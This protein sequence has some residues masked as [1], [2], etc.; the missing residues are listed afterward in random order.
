VLYLLG[1]IVF[2]LD[3]NIAWGCYGLHANITDLDGGICSVPSSLTDGDYTSLNHFP[4]HCSKAFDGSGASD[5]IL[6]DCLH[7]PPYN[8]SS[9]LHVIAH[10]LTLSAGSFLGR[11]PTK[12]S[13]LIALYSKHLTI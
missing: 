8:F 2:A 9:T 3:Y 13:Q 10:I 6:N 5:Q 11:I 4:L 12:Y 7:P 1:S